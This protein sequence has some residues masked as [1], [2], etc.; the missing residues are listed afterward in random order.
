MISLWGWGSGIEAKGKKKLY[1][2][3][4]TRIGIWVGVLEKMEVVVRGWR[5]FCS[6]IVGGRSEKHF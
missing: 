3:K 6:Q 5:E 4:M 2:T 1:F